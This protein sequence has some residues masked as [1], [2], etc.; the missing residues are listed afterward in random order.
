MRM[1]VGEAIDEADRR[2]L[3]KIRFLTRY[4]YPFKQ[5]VS[6]T[7]QVTFWIHT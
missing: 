2:I 3:S 7:V 6:A 1:S 5:L 4:G